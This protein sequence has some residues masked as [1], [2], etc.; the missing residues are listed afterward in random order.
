[1]TTVKVQTLINEI[2]DALILDHGYDFLK[3]SVKDQE[4]L[5]IQTFFKSR[6]ED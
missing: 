1:M 4:A 6:T 3:L 2:R 5:I